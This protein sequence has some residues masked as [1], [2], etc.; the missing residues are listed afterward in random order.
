MKDLQQI[1]L[2]IQTLSGQVQSLESKLEIIKES[3]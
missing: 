1:T 3:S 2:A